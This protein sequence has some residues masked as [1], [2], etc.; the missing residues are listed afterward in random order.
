MPQWAWTIV[1]VAAGV[2]VLWLALV[3]MLWAARPDEVTVKDSMR[4]LPDLLRLLRRL[5]AD[6]TLPRGVRV[7]LW[8]LLG[9]L[10]MPIDL[11]PDFIPVLGYLDDVILVP[12]GILLAVRMI[13]PGLMDELRATA[14]KRAERPVSRVGA[15]VVVTL[16]IAAAILLLWAF[17]PRRVS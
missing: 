3:A 7:R 16:W 1:G 4:L 11:V 2:A 10:A 6:R 9:Y 17:W 5:A 14:R 13:P 8:L 15:L 12:L